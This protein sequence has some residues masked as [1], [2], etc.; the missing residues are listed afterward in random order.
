[1]IAMSPLLA[2]DEWVGASGTSGS[3]G[4]NGGGGGGG[5][6]VFGG[7]GGGGAG[8]AS[9]GILIKGG[10]QCAELFQRKYFLGR[11]RGTRRQRWAI[12]GEFRFGRCGGCHAVRQH[13]L[14]GRNFDQ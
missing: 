3:S 14:N 11:D 10:N 1:M 8:G 9:Y 12:D 7:G 6:G 4:Q 13:S 5:Q 2:G